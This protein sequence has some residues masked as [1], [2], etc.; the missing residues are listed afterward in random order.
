MSDLF[1]T[2]EYEDLL[3]KDFIMGG[4]GPVFY[5][6]W[7]I[8]LEIAKRAGILYPLDFTP[9]TLE[10]R[11][12][13]IKAIQDKDFIKIDKPEPY[14]IVTF[15][16]KPPYISHCGIVLP[17]CTTFIHILRN[18]SVAVQRLEHRVLARRIDGFYKLR[19]TP[20]K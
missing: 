3:G 17:N 5:D 1:K 10:A 4:R 8:C 6:C 19:E 13:A 7:G 18:H 16:L 15:K 12:E 14:C 20:C 9:D 11:D 2:I